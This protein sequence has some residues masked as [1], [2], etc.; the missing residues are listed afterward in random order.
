MLTGLTENRDAFRLHMERPLSKFDRLVVVNLVETA[1]GRQE[2]K[3]T[4][5]FVRQLLLFNNPNVTYVGFDFHEYWY[6]YH[7]HHYFWIICR[8][9]IGHDS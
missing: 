3:I 6:V 5:A 4:E 1:P 9:L 2:S 8:V 7:M